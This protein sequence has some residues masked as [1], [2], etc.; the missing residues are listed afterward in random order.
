[1]GGEKAQEKEIVAGNPH[2]KNR[3]KEAEKIVKSAIS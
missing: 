2:A 3:Y 1:M